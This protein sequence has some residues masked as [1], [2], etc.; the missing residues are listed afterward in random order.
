MIPEFLFIFLVDSI[1]TC[2]F[3]HQWSKYLL[4]LNRIFWFFPPP[5]LRF[6]F[7][8]YLT[9]VMVSVPLCI[10]FLL[11]TRSHCI[12]YSVDLLLMNCFPLCLSWK[13]FILWW[14]IKD[15]F[16]GNNS[17]WG[18]A[19]YSQDLKCTIQY[20]VITSVKVLRG[21]TFH[22]AIVMDDCE[23]PNM[24]AGNWTWAFCVVLCSVLQNLNFLAQYFIQFV[25]LFI[26]FLNLMFL[27]CWSVDWRIIEINDNF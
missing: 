14:L 24:G 21:I 25:D 27:I 10:K 8:W 11:C 17:I 26:H 12:F 5:L 20:F 22:G 19:I 7:S 9:I 3:L 13:V 1:L 18:K 4:L 15:N 6:T 23:L 16:T 2:S